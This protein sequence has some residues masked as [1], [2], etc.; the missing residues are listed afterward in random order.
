MTPA[1]SRPS[2]PGYDVPVKFDPSR[3]IITPEDAVLLSVDKLP[4]YLDHVLKALT[5]HTEARTSFI[6]YVVIHQ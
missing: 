6:T 4:M 5:L 3:P 2:S 1:S